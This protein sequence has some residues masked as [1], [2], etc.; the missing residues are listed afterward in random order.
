MIVQILKS[1]SPTLLVIYYALT[2]ISVPGCW[3][4]VPYII[5]RPLMGTYIN[6]TIL[7]DSENSASLAANA[8]FNEFSRIELLMSPYR[9]ESDIYAINNRKGSTAEVSTETL[10]LVQRS[11]DMSEKTGGAF[12]ITFATVSRLWNLRAERFIPPS[13]QMVNHYLSSLNYRLISV[14]K[15]KS[16]IEIKKSLTKIGLGGI[17]K[18]YAV[19]RAIAVLHSLGI[20]N[21]IVEAGGDLQVIGSNNGSPWTVGLKHPREQAIIGVIQLESGDSVVTSGDYE[22]YAMHNGT[23]YHHILDPVTGFP[24]RQFSSVTVVCSDP[25]EADA[26]STAFFVMGKEKVY[27]FLSMNSGIKV[28]LIDDEMHIAASKDMKGRLTL[29]RNVA[30]EWIE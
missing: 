3:N 16:T 5:S 10:E 29:L 22:R 30:V 17:A 20:R 24:A 8:V 12:D 21:A 14:N 7:A 4:M 19:A 2:L 9:N 23:R 18:G 15:A 6:L 1:M 26:L 27:R 28:I 13:P 25:I 11:L